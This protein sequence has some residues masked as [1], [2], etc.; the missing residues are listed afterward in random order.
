MTMSDD[1]L[2][3]LAH[4]NLNA[5]RHEWRRRFST[6]P[7]LFKSKDLL[8][9]ALVYRLEPTQ[10]GATARLKKRLT[11]LAQRFDEDPAYDP[12]PRLAP[13]IGS[14]LVRD[15][16]GVRHVVLV[17]PEGFR[18]GERAYASLTEVAKA[19]TGKHQSGPRFF[20][21]VGAKIEMAPP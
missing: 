7:P 10:K 14:A 1:E 12:A 17:T 18:Y 8:L 2:Q 6:E 20:G 19:I 21:L 15:W 16:N 5:L 11:E 9:R 13:A 3:S 4:L